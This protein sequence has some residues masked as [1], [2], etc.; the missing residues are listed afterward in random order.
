MLVPGLDAESGIEGHGAVNG[1]IRVLEIKPRF[2]D[3]SCRT[4]LKFGAVVMD[5]LTYCEV[6]A[7]VETRAGRIGEGWGG[8][9]LADFW[10]FPSKVV[11][12]EARDAAMREI[13][14][15][16]ARLVAGIAVPKHPIDVFFET[17]E[18]LRGI[19]KAVSSQM[20]FA[21][22]MPFLG[23]L[24]CASPVDA[25]LHD[26]FGNANSIC[27]YDGYGPDFMDH[28]LSRWLGSAYKGKYPTDYLRREHQ[29]L[30]PVFHLVG[31]LDKLR[32]SEIGDED[33]KDG[34]PVSLDQWIEQDGLTCLKVKL[35]GNDLEW[36]INRIVEVAAVA[37]EVQG[38]Q[39]KDELFLS[40]DTNE[41]C[42]TADYIVEM[43]VKVR[44]RSPRAYDQILYVE[45]P[46][47]RD[48]RARR[49]DMRPIARLKPVIIDES[50]MTL[51]DFDLAMEL[52]WSGI[53]L[54]TCKG[55]SGALVFA[56]KAMQEGIPYSIQD[57][58][59]PAL[60]LIHSVGL[61]ARL[62]PIKGVEANARQ[63]FPATSQRHARVHPKLFKLSAGCVSTESLGATGLGYRVEEI[64][65]S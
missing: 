41:M 27:S 51:E 63:F 6:R 39:G 56:S 18:G 28:D 46:T 22:E 60:A 45:Q 11:P 61:A 30:V 58:T 1:D 59:N 57:L 4:P 62:S 48:L 36:D 8:I 55:H 15:R 64:K 33:P 17:E 19:A 21:E 24:V 38:R 53:A 47:E 44:E 49:F 7:K 42:E 32:S 25:A 14:S 29:R 35:R 12:H 10:A 23:A 26:A 5:R 9:F 3:E 65:R 52:G 34:L 13:V 37:R 16:Y 31:G 40:A 2:S 43:L 54:K 20:G 50:L